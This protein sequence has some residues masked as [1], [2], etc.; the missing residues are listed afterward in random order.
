MTPQ[1]VLAAEVVPTVEVVPDSMEMVHESVETLCAHCGTF[2]VGDVFRE[3]FFQARRRARRCGCCGLL[4]KDYDHA[5]RWFHDMERFDCEIYIPD[6]EKLEMNGNT[7]ILPHQVVKRLE[8]H[9]VNMK[10]TKIHKLSC[11]N[12]LLLL[13]SPAASGRRLLLLLVVVVVRITAC[14]CCSM[15]LVRL[16]C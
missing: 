6:V 4:H 2:H 7:I 1:V 14:C 9:I 13:A 12:K 10:D 11:I 15:L 5:A 16:L 8:E 3:A